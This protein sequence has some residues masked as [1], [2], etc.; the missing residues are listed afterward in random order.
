MLIEDKWIVEWPFSAN[1]ASHE[2]IIYPNVK[3]T[4]ET[5]GDERIRTAT[6]TE[7]ILTPLSITVEARADSAKNNKESMFVTW[8]TVNMKDRTSFVFGKTGSNS[9]DQASLKSGNV[10][11]YGFEN[12]VNVEDV[13]S[14][15][16]GETEITN[17]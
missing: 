15:T 3:A 16:I 9:S 8:V 11:Y 1:D 4:A 14:I 5:T 17:Q 2:K 7:V 6:I 12:I 10:G 13:E